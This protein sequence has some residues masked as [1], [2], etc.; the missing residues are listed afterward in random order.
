[1]SAAFVVPARAV[2]DT[3]TLDTSSMSGTNRTSGSTSLSALPSAQDAVVRTWALSDR[4]SWLDLGGPG[5][6]SE[7]VV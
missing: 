2:A 3:V 7:G 5:P 4:L 6:R 1:V